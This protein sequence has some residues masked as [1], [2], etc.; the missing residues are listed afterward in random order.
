MYIILFLYYKIIMEQKED[1]NINGTSGFE[2]FVSK[3]RIEGEQ[4]T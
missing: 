4:R 3:I 2:E 1:S